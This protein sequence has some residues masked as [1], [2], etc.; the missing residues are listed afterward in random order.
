[1]TRKPHRPLPAPQRP[2]GPSNKVQLEVSATRMTGPI[3]PPDVLRQY[4]ALQLGLA[5]R[6]V[7]MAEKEQGHRHHCEKGA[8][9]GH[10]DSVK[11][12]QHYAFAV[13]AVSLVGGAGLGWLFGWG[14]S[15]APIVLAGIGIASAY[16]S[17]YPHNTESQQGRQDGEDEQAE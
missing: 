16:L 13:V 7:A 12:G 9:A 6:I 5:N 11:R 17:R 14:A 10:F 15:V 3:P 1:M 8:L 2:L 4:D